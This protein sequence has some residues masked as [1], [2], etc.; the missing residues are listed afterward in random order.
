MYRSNVRKNKNNNKNNNNNKLSFVYVLIN[1]F[2]I[3]LYLLIIDILSDIIDYF[4]TN[5]LNMDVNKN[6]ISKRDIIKM[7]TINVPLL[8]FLYE[9]YTMIYYKSFIVSIYLFVNLIVT[10]INIYI[11]IVFDNNDNNSNE[12]ININNISVLLLI[13]GIIVNIGGIVFGYLS[14]IDIILIFYV[15]NRTVKNIFG[16]SI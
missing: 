16:K 8:V 1:T 13:L 15:M 2:I 4:K 5:I 14:I 7:V 3:P 10:I 12:G 6:I 11:R 9:I